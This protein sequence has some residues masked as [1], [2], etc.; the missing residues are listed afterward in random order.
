MP[1]NLTCCSVEVI[2]FQEIKLEVNIPIA[3]LSQH[4][5]THIEQLEKKATTKFYTKQ[6]LTK[7]KMKNTDRQV[8]IKLRLLLQA[9]MKIKVKEHSLIPNT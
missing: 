6:V 3:V 4:Y 2:K 1:N 8:W 9:I 5:L 7:I